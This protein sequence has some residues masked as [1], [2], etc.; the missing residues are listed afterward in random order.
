MIAKAW[1]NI[2]IRGRTSESERR[3]GRLLLQHTDTSE[4][5]QEER[6]ERRTDVTRRCSYHQESFMCTHVSLLVRPFSLFLVIR[7]FVPGWHILER[8]TSTSESKT[9]IRLPHTINTHKHKTRNKHTKRNSI[10][11]GSPAFAAATS[12][13]ATGTRYS[14]DPQNTLGTGFPNTNTR[15]GC[16]RFAFLPRYPGMTITAY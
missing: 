5:V 2:H 8:R 13:A 12:T 3:G 15:R 11:S 14:F 10:I 4:S 6:S 7:S 9:D 1:P 16:S